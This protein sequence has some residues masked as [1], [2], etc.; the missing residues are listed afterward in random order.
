MVGTDSGR[1]RSVWEIDSDSEDVQRMAS[2]VLSQISLSGI[3]AGQIF[4]F[5]LPYNLSLIV[6][7]EITIPIG[8]P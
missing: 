7:P 5:A 8:C 1:T 2:L 4:R 3:L 6:T